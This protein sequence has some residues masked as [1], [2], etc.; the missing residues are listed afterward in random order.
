M[1]SDPSRS[2]L[3]AFPPVKTREQQI[4]IIDALTNDVAGTFQINVPNQGALPGVPDHMVT[5][6]PVIIDKGGLHRIQLEP[7]PN[8]LMLEVIQPHV[9]AIEWGVEAYVTGDAEMQE[10]A[11][12]AHPRPGGPGTS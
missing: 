4:P 10:D 11:C 7:L 2:A 12:S 6:L 1:T 8:K 3:E 9:L 5:E